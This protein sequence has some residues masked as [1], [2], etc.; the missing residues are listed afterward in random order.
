M[1][2][3]AINHIRVV[4]HVQQED[5]DPVE[6]MVILN[7]EMISGISRQKLNLKLLIKKFRI[8]LKPL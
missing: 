8:R 1:E 7:A 6:D 5:R 2:R 4:H 3:L